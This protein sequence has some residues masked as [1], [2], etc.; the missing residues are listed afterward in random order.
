MNKKLFLLFFMAA[1]LL[2]ACK[3]TGIKKEKIDLNGMIYDTQN[4]PVVNYR[5]SIDGK[6]MCTSDIG[7]RF[8]I[9]SVEKGE[10]VFSGSGDGYLGMEK[11]IQVADKS[12]ILY[13]RVSDIESMFNEAFELIKKNELDKAEKIICEVLESHNENEDAL[14]FRNTIKKLREMNEKTSE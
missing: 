11:S 6:E 5:I 13:I 10:H 8:V 14:Y 12:Q 4:R 3:S 2:S 7:G 1:L 9:S